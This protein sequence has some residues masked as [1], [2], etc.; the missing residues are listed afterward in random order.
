MV[1]IVVIILIII[2]SIT[3]LYKANNKA[4]TLIKQPSPVPVVVNDLTVDEQLFA[5]KDRSRIDIPKILSEK[6]SS[7]KS[8]PPALLTLF[9]SEAIYNK[10]KSVT[11]DTKYSGFEIELSYPK[12]VRDAYFSV[13]RSLKNEKWTN[14]YGSRYED[15]GILDIENN[16]YLA[17]V[18]FFKTNDLNT[19]VKV[20]I[21]NKK[22]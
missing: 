20:L 7:S 2:L 17:T 8:L 11:Y 15:S 1:V 18:I 14:L 22:I 5:L 3:Y 21:V 10:V 6:E 19:D 12:A 16:G 4:K 9:G 13:L